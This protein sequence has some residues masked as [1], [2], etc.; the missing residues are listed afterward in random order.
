LVVRCWRD[1]PQK[2]PCLLVLDTSYYGTICRVG[3]CTLFF[4]DTRDVECYVTAAEKR[5]S[6]DK[7]PMY[8][9]P[10]RNQIRTRT[11]V[12]TSTQTSNGHNNNKEA[13]YVL[14]DAY[15]K[16]RRC[17]SKER[18]RCRRRPRRV[19]SVWRRYKSRAAT[20]RILAGEDDDP[21]LYNDDCK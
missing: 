20:D 18:A 15:G 21:P 10:R 12:S 2:S 19:C 16:P 5:V 4:Q 3:E 8:R 1:D 9:F 11:Y 14:L 17:S 6:K 7:I 13:T